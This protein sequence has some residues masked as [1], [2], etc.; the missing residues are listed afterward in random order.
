MA[1]Y[2]ISIMFTYTLIAQ[3][4]KLYVFSGIFKYFS[5]HFIYYELNVHEFQGI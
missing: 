3:Q 2:C 5:Y 1:F 4:Y